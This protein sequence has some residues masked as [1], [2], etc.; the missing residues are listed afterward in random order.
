[1]PSIRFTR[2]Q[3]GYDSAG[4]KTTKKQVFEGFRWVGPAP[5]P[6]QPYSVRGADLK[7][8]NLTG[9]PHNRYNGVDESWA[10]VALD[11][12]S[13]AEESAYAR[14]FDS[15]GDIVNRAS[16]GVSL[17]EGREAIEL[18]ATRGLSIFRAFRALRRGRF[19]DFLDELHIRDRIGKRSRWSKPKDAAALALEY[20][21]GWVPVLQDIHDAA[22]VLQGELPHGQTVR[23]YGRSDVPYSY[24]REY[25]VHI[26]DVQGHVD[27]RVQILAKAKIENPNLLLLNQLGLINPAVVVWETVPFSFIVDAVGLPVQKFLEQYTRFAGLS[28]SDFIVSTKVKAEVIDDYDGGV[29]GKRRSRD[30]AYRMTRELPQQLGIP[31]R[32]IEFIKRLDLERGITA[33]SLVVSLFAPEERLPRWKARRVRKQLTK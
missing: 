32:N 7:I 30:V 14:A 22:S 23:G 13:W 18:I 9:N 12:F 11:Q 29:Y 27:H 15:L 10:S 33:M 5:R 25:G 6:N 26:T 16:V 2:F 19:G 21:F 1:M 8:L 20:Q 28:L 4:V 31:T 3:Q 17:A 24:F